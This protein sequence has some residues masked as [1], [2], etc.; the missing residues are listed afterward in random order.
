MSLTN[1]EKKEDFSE[2][3]LKK[4]MDTSFVIE[5]YHEMYLSIKNEKN[6]D[7]DRAHE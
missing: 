3:N 2:N 5:G 4:I 6:K 7:K 1:G